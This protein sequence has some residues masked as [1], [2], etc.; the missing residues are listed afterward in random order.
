[1][2][3][4]RYILFSPYHPINNMNAKQHLLP[5]PIELPIE[6]YLSELPLPINS[7]KPLLS[8]INP[9]NIFDLGYEALGVFFV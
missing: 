5:L 7:N 9:L 4:K 2:I 3:L 8:F 6:A 1:M